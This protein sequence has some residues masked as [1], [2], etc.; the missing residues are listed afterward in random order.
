MLKKK[1]AGLTRKSSQSELSPD[2]PPST[3]FEYGLDLAIRLH[4]QGIEGDANAVRKA[5]IA[6][7][8]L[9]DGH[10]GHPIADAYHGS[11]MALMARDE[12]NV[13]QKMQLAKRGLELL[14]QAVAS[15][16]RDRTIRMLRGKVAYR[17]PESFFRRTETAIED[18]IILIDGEIRSPGGFDKETYSTLISELAEAYERINR[19]E[20]AALCWKNLNKLTE[21]PAYRKLAQRKMKPE[22][23]LPSSSKAVETKPPELRDW[24][25]AAVLVAGASVVHWIGRR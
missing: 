12:T 24:I 11:V 3:P 18:Y 21:N 20:E 6:F 15:E 17:L 22:K 13:M 16:P 19:H 25:G 8:R 4:H 5:N 23:S 9:R 10:P 7:Q 14:D 2:A 1:A